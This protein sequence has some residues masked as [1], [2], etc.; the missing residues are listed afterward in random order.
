MRWSN[1]D[2]T[3]RNMTE[4]IKGLQKLLF[5]HHLYLGSR[6]LLRP[7]VNNSFQ[8]ANTVLHH[9]YTMCSHPRGK[10]S[11]VQNFYYRKPLCEVSAG[12]VA[13]HVRLHLSRLAHSPH[14]K[15]KL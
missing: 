9:S 14:P 15:K 4:P 6:W 12:T 5:Y 13:P 3:T 2:E 10:D 1:K 7:C 11:L 8:L